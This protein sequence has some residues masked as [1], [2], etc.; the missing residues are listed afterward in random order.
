MFAGSWGA[1]EDPDTSAIAS[2]LNDRPKY[3]VSNT[4][5]D[6]QWTGTSVLTG[7]I[8]KAIR[9]LK[10]RHEGTLLVP[11]SGELV[12][13]LLAN[14]L[15]DQLDVVIYPVVVGQGIRLFPDAGPDMALEL[16]GSRTS[17]AGLT[18]QS[19]RPMGRPQYQQ[20]TLDTDEMS[21]VGRGNRPS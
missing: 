9:D 13:W 17:P 5:S 11:G 15:V 1:F 18:M 14:N 8:A 10:T 3:V 21:V 20:A 6:P 7:D 19:Y 16:L 4:L 12:R 2:A